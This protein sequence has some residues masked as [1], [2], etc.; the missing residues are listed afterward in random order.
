MSS[1]SELYQCLNTAALNCAETC[2]TLQECSSCGCVALPQSVG[3]DWGD[4]MDV[5]FCLLPI[6]FLVYATIKPNPLPTT[7]SLPA[8]ALL[9]YLV[10]LMYLQSDPLLTTGS[11]ILGLHEAITPL[12]IM[13]GAIT[14]FESMEATYCLPYMM[15]EIKALTAGHPIAEAMLYVY[16]CASTKLQSSLTM[17]FPLSPFFVEPQYLLFCLHGG[18][19]AQQDL[20]AGPHL[21]LCAPRALA[22]PARHAVCDAHQLSGGP[23]PGRRAGAAGV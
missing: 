15:R 4:V 23:G 19:R 2:T 9:M 11:V 18:G 13:A 22:W 6:L 1:S 3:G 14:L 10:R 5:I 8:A 21:A 7:T 12:S 16:D 17:Y 20:D